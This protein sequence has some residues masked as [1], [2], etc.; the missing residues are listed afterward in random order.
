MSLKMPL[1][2]PTLLV[3]EDICRSNIRRMYQK[4]SASGTELEPHFKTHQSIAIGKWFRDEGVRSI[5]VSSIDMAL[6]FAGAGWKNITIAFPINVLQ[7]QDIKALAARVNLT[8]LVTERSAIVK[9]L[10]HVDVMLEVMIEVDCG[11]NRSGIWWED[12]HDIGILIDTLKGTQHK[13]KGFYCHSGQTYHVQGAAAV[14]EIFEDSIHKLSDL[15]SRFADAR[16]RISVGD[17]PSCSLA[18]EFD[19]VDSIHPGNFVFYDLTQAHIGSC[20]ETDIGIAL[21]V[22]VVSK[23]KSKLQLVVHGGGVHLSKDVLN[24]P[25]GPI[26]GKMVSLTDTGWSFDLGSNYV[27]SISQEHGIIEVSEKVFE[28]IDVG[29]IV[30]ILPVHSCMT[31]DVI[32]EMQTTEGVK[33][34]HF[35]KS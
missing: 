18:K 34:D 32:G 12:Y 21:A 3:D 28:Q 10:N 14:L 29:D 1:N 5:T 2:K 35:K 6:Y 26:Y 22:P 9:L 13:F 25:S 17:T 23:Q 4:A 15:K 19:G 33:L 7:I 11:Y 31:A 8:V 20:E 30:A 16:P 27:T 24:L